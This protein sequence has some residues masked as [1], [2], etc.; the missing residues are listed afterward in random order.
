MSTALPKPRVIVEGE[1]FPIKP[2]DINAEEFLSEAFGNMESEIS[3]GYIVRLMQGKGDWKPF[4]Y[5][6]LN[7][8]YKRTCNTKGYVGRYSFN[9]L[10]D[11]F[12]VVSVNGNYFDRLDVI[13]KD[14]DNYFVTD[15]FIL[16]CYMSQPIPRTKPA[17]R[18]LPAFG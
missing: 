11:D 2:H 13:V 9:H 3:A 1:D 15:Q 16:R 18:V 8:F 7:E 4:T 10:I 6:E 5:V 12:W 17:A 14:G